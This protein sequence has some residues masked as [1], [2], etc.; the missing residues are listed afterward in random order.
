MEKTKQT[1]T[2]QHSD[3]T[4]ISRPDLGFAS[5][6]S[7]EPT[8]K[9]GRS[10]N[11]K[12]HTKITR[13][14]PTRQWCMNFYRCRFRA[15]DFCRWCWGH[16]SQ[17]WWKKGHHTDLISCLGF[18]FKWAKQRGGLR[19]E[20][21]GLFTPHHSQVWTL[22]KESWLDVQLGL[23]AWT[24]E[25]TTATVQRRGPVTRGPILESWWWDRGGD[26]L[27]HRCQEDGAWIG[28]YKQD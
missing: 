23:E 25:G 22:P 7:S 28:G 10:H 15:F 17:P 3:D 4:Q 24:K 21:I 18:P 14:A 13:I 12:T 26:V 19:V 1:K 11:R 27:L 16:C 9:R 5:R 20:W 8:Q 6:K 2:R